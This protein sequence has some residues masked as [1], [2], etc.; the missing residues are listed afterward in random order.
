MRM[1]VRQAPTLVMSMLT[2]LTMW[3][4]IHADATTVSLVT[5]TLAIQ[6]GYYLVFQGVKCFRNNMRTR[7]F[8]C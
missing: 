1:N 6:V 2:A 8:F 4:R 3:G 5:D 7:F